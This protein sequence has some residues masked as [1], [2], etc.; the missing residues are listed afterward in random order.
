MEST[1]EA[2]E[3][4]R[5]GTRSSASAIRRCG[6]DEQRRELHVASDELSRMLTGLERYLLRSDRR[7]I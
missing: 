6:A 4:Q 2:V 1:L 3:A 5:A 7:R